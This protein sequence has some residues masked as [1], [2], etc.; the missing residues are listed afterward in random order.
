MR[1]HS[2]DAATKTSGGDLGFRTRQ[3]L[4]AL[5][6]PVL[7]ESALALKTVGQ[8][9]APV[10]TDQGIHLLMLQ[11]RQVAN[12]QTFEQARPRIVQRLA[13]ERRAKSLDTLVQ[14][15]RDGTRVEIKEDVL[16][17]VNPE[18]APTAT[19]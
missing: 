2:Q 16:S 17:E 7:A 10:E 19:P 4:E 15:L 14:S 11:A 3:E 18:A 9:S 8:V 12:E 1:A 6:G 5:G 13:T